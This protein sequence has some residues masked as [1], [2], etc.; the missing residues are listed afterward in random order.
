MSAFSSERI[1]QLREILARATPGPWDI[2]PPVEYDG[3][4]DEFRGGYTSPASI[5]GGDGNPVCAFGIA[6]GS[7]HLFEND[8]DHQLIKLTRTEF[9]AALDEIERLQEANEELER[10]AEIVSVD[11]ENDCWCAMRKL[12]KMTGY[13]F[14]DEGVTADEAFEHLADDIK[15]G[16][17]QLNLISANLSRLK[18]DLDE[19]VGLVKMLAPRVADFSVSQGVQRGLYASHLRAARSFLSRMEGR[20]DG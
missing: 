8:A 7:G 1:S 3:D 6:E 17:A 4:D 19:A 11:F 14:T 15:A 12:L 10:N 18:A 20:K 16:N 9:P 13:D 2:I 5:E